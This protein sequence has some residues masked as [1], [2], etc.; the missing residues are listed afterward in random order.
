[1]SSRDSH[2]HKQKCD[3]ES[4][5]S[6]ICPEKCK[7]KCFKKECEFKKK[8][9]AKSA[10]EIYCKYG[11]AVVEIHSEFILVGN[12]YEAGVDLPTVGPYDAVADN[13][14]R[15][16]ICL[17]GNGFF[18]R[19][20]DKK[21]RDQKE[22]KA[23][24]IV[25]PSQLIL[26]PPTVSSYAQRYPFDTNVY[27]GPYPRLRE[28]QNK[29][30][31]ASRILVSVFNV[32][33]KGASYYYEATLIGVDGAGDVALLKI[34]EQVG[35][36]ACNPRIERCHPY[37]EFADLDK[38]EKAQD[39]LVDGEKVYLIGDSVNTGV[40]NSHGII[41]GRL[42]DGSYTDYSGT[43]LSEAVL[44]DASVF[45]DNAGMPILN[46]E[47][48]VIGMQTTALSASFDIDMAAAGNTVDVVTGV[49]LTSNDT[50]IYDRDK[51]VAPST[52]W[53]SKHEP[54]EN[55]TNGTFALYGNEAVIWDKDEP[56]T[57]S[58]EYTP[59]NIARADAFELTSNPAVVHHGI[60][61]G[62]GS[63]G[64]PYTWK[65]TSFEVDKLV[66]SIN[67][68]T[69]APKLPYDGAL[70]LVP[71]T[72]KLI[73]ADST[74]ALM[75]GAETDGSAP[76]KVVL[77]NEDDGTGTGTYVLKNISLDKFVDSTTNTVK[78][79]VNISGVATNKFK[80]AAVVMPVANFD[81]DTGVPMKNKD[82]TLVNAPYDT[83]AVDPENPIVVDGL[84]VVPFEAI[85]KD[86]PDK[87]KILE[88]EGPDKVKYTKPYDKIFYVGK[89]ADGNKDATP[90][91]IVDGLKVVPKANIDDKTGGL[92]TANLP[93]DTAALDR[94]SI[95]VAGAIST[96][97]GLGFV[98]GPTARFIKKVVARLA[99]KDA[100]PNECRKSD[101]LEAIADAKDNYYRNLKGYLGMAYDVF[102]APMYD[103]AVN[104]TS[105]AVNAGYIEFSINDVGGIMFSNHKNELAG[106]RVLGLAGLN[107]ND[108]TATENGL[109]YVPGGLVDHT[110]GTDTEYFSPDLALYES[111]LR[112][113]V[114][115]GAMI[116]FL[117]DT[118]LGDL[119]GQHAPSAVLWRLCPGSQVS[120]EYY[121]GG[122]TNSK[123]AYEYRDVS[124]VTLGSMP[125]FVDYP[126]YAVLKF[127]DL[128]KWFGLPD[129]YLV[130]SQVPQLNI[131]GAGIFRPS[132]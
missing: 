27:A 15:R 97:S 58:T 49:T 69:G 83:I 40:F 86:T 90:Y 87:G 126:W 2:C 53:T 115:P 102:T 109:Y 20:K 63:T 105:G 60:T 108:A 100:C 66:N 4:T 94:T 13:I 132:L 96:R 48:K 9:C 55:L 122:N 31:A 104:Y 3:D 56:V 33:N 14:A 22:E 30:V 111:P 123:D 34:E 125:Q 17:E 59:H 73:P 99:N 32:N 21:G 71:H 70:A 107:P 64:N 1:M 25:C 112:G 11:N 118:Q 37:L 46:A 72:V 117:N 26:V 24:Y 81:A 47:G 38:C 57:P 16:D 78:A 93:F 91:V 44:V 129:K 95:A 106:V 127:P 82:G 114:T 10:E 67:T 19:G 12:N 130:S 65:S 51:P 92:G 116:K 77:P 103:V 85:N 79:S 42:I 76:P 84:R 62:D 120:Y 75:N 41:Q 74:V 54:V 39:K 110:A 88:V 101:N 28:M 29:M 113:K 119:D 36:N 61:T 18:I 80:D 43:L 52:L 128:R 121:L 124:K 6:E 98:A 8:L 7:L 131:S 23:R 68:T 89:D 35:R 45:G 5:I 50:V